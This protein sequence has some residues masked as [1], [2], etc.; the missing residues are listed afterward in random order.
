MK[1]AIIGTSNS[2]RRNNYASALATEHD[3]Y[4]LSSGRVPYYAHIKTVLKNTDLL[5]TMDVIIIDHYINDVNFYSLHM[6]DNYKERLGLFY[7]LL[8]ELEVP[9]LN[10]LTAIYDLNSEKAYWYYEWT[11]ELSSKFSFNILDLNDVKFPISMYTDS[12][13]LKRE[14]SY[15]IGLQLSNYLKTEVLQFPLKIDGFK[16]PFKLVAEK[17]LREFPQCEEYEFTNSLMKI[18]CF[19]LKGE[20]KLSNHGVLL[21]LGYFNSRDQEYST[22]LTINGKNYSLDGER[23]YHEAAPNVSGV[24]SFKP[25][26]GVCKNIHNLVERKKFSNIL[27]ISSDY[28]FPSV[29][30]FLFL[31]RD[32]ANYD[33]PA[34]ASKKVMIENLEKNILLVCGSLGKELQNK[35]VE[36]VR[37]AAIAL[38]NND[39]QLSLKLLRIVKIYRPESNFVLR[40]I[41]EYRSKIKEINS[42]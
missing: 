37:K 20:I 17:E 13:H 9:V 40:K 31:K 5:K 33:F 21:S 3:V 15:F 29:V 8:A 39:F 6:D 18:N 36:V 14:V 32:L 10:Y 42:A 35:E 4:N 19:R 23:Y 25:I 30:D 7:G 34:G 41:K 2:V 1:I 12:I 26:T 38:E 22:G 27:N 11:K 16:N 28:S 24:I